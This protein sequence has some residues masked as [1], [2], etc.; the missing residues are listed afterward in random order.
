MR[1]TTAEQKQLFSDASADT[2]PSLPEG[3]RYQNEF[4]DR[5]MESQLVAELQT[6]ELKRFEFHG[7]LGNRRVIS[8]GW[9]YNYERREVQK[10]DEAPSFLGGLRAKAAEFAGWSPEDLKQVGINEYKPGAGIGWHRDKPQFGDVIGI[11]LL[12]V[13][14]M[15]LHKRDAQKWMRRAVVLQP[16][17]IYVLSGPARQEW[18]HSIPP[19]ST[20]RYAIVFRTLAGDSRETPDS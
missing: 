18:E 12:S 11:S 9:R 5:Q 8:F 4:I 16:R 10:A 20:L 1:R 2:G 3:F 17:S 14:E 19:V 7:H 13:A 15:R 6:L